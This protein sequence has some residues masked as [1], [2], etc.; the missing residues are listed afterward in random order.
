MNV[1][2]DDVIRF[3][4]KDGKFSLGGDSKEKK[5]FT[6]VTGTYSDTTF[7]FE[8]TNPNDS[9]QN[10]EEETEA[11]VIGKVIGNF[12]KTGNAW[13]GEIT[14]TINPEVV[15]KISNA[16]YSKE[17][18]T[19][20]LEVV[21]GEFTYGPINFK[22]TIKAVDSVSVDKPEEVLPFSA[23]TQIAGGQPARATSEEV[24][25]QGLENQKTAE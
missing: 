14:N 6:L 21:M 24:K 17:E 22:T 5:D 2:K 3:Q 11:K 12:A 20:S 23:L 25:T 10:S 15:V 7:T 19:L 18:I 9:F 4:A 8:A 13:A 1:S 16:S